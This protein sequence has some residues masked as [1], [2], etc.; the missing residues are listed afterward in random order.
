MP[1]RQWSDQVILS[2]SQETKE[3]WP[4]KHKKI[5]HGLPTDCYFW[6]TLSFQM[7]F[8]A[9]LFLPPETVVVWL[10]DSKNWKSKWEPKQRD[11]ALN[12]GEPKTG[13]FNAFLSQNFDLCACPNSK[14]QKTSWNR[15]KRKRSVLESTFREGWDEIGSNGAKKGYVMLQRT[16]FSKLVGWQWVNKRLLCRLIH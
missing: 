5:M 9:K 16:F 11:C 6:P 13:E 8:E 1:E 4:R 7:S 3:L 10:T 14:C 15:K 12:L 2:N